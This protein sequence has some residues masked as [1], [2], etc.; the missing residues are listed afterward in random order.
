MAGPVPLADGARQLVE[1]LDAAGVTAYLDPRDLEPPCAWV[2]PGTIST[3][4]TLAL[5]ELL[6]D[7]R[8]Y[9][10]APGGLDVPGQLDALG[11]M[12]PLALGVLGPV[13]AE[14][15]GIQLPNL[16]PDPLPGLQLTVQTS[17]TS[18]D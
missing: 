6:V 17:L 9:L 4:A 15:V 5:D 14:P 18:E 11:V 13:D 2:T 10:I 16:A 1:L 8:V 7:W 12:L 3:D